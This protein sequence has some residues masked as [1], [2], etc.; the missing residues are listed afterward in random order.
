ME[1]LMRFVQSFWRPIVLA[2]LALVVVGQVASWG[3]TALQMHSIDRLVASAQNDENEA[4]RITGDPYDNPGRSPRS[5]TLQPK[6]DIFLR[7]N[8]SYQL[9]AIYKDQAVIDGQTVKAGDRI[10]KATVEKILLASVIIQEDGKPSREIKMFQG[11]GGS[12]GGPMPMRGM[13]GRGRPS[14]AASGQGVPSQGS[15]G[16]A[17][18]EGRQLGGEGFPGGGRADMREMFRRFREGGMSIEDMPPEMQQRIR[19]GRARRGGMRQ[20]REQGPPR[21]TGTQEIVD[22]VVGGE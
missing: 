15:F 17:S 6:A 1:S 14:G 5:P 13:M 22:V 10:E 3:Y 16:G 8:P 18:G 9:S 4:R 12:G 7:K 20:P 19:E 2:V 11:R 21:E